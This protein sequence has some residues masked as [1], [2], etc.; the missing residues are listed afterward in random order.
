MGFSTHLLLDRKAFH[1]TSFFFLCRNFV[2]VSD[3][4]H[5]FLPP[6]F[7]ISNFINLL[8]GLE[9]NREGIERNGLDVWM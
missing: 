6:R 4:M 3:G 1:L 2:I 9:E 5:S 7:A 8:G